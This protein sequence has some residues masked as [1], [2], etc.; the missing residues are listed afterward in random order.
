[1]T[2]HRT[3]LQQRQMHMPSTSAAHSSYKA[4]TQSPHAKLGAAQH[5]CEC[6]PVY[7]CKKLTGYNRLGLQRALPPG[8]RSWRKLWQ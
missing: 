7:C 1:M 5:S 3:P 2:G 8:L 6:S 4:R